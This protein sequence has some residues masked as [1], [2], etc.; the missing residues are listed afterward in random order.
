MILK[1]ILSFLMLTPLFN[2]FSQDSLKIY[3]RDGTIKS[4]NKVYGGINSIHGK[5][6]DKSHEKHKSEEVLFYESRSNSSGVKVLHLK[7]YRKKGELYYGTR[8]TLV[9]AYIYTDSLIISPAL[10]GEASFSSATSQFQTSH[11]VDLTKVLKGKKDKGIVYYGGLISPEK[12]KTL[13]LKNFADCEEA[14]DIINSYEG[15]GKRKMNWMKIIIRLQEACPKQCYDLDKLKK[16]IDL[17]IEKQES[18]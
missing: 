5:N 9:H 13:L 1:T 3:L 8:S 6:L 16:Q 2:S 15:K 18:R 10:S 12:V 17:L 14:K 7:F 4:Y 11:I